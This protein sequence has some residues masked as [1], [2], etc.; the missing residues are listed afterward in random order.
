MLF[1][2]LATDL[3]I[4]PIEDMIERVHKI[5]AD[6]LG[7]AHQEEERL[8]FEELAMHEHAGTSNQKIQVD[9]GFKD[10]IKEREDK[11]KSNEPM[12][13][14]MLEQTL[15]KIGALLALGFG[16][17]GSQ[18]IAKNMAKGGD[19]N[20]MLPGIK[21][22]SIFGFCDIR[23]FTDA[24]E[25]LQEGVMLFVNEIGEICH[26]IVDR[27]SGAANKNI[28][29]AFLLVWKFDPQD[30]TI[31]EE[32]GDITAKESARVGQLCD[33]SVISFVL[34]IAELKKSR[35]MVKYNTHK[36]LIERMGEGYEVKLGMGLHMGYAIEGAIG[37]YYKIDASYLSPHVNMSARLEGA[38]KAFGVPLLISGSLYVKCTRR[39][40][41]HCR[42]VDWVVMA[43]SDEPVKL[44]TVDVDSSLLALESPQPT[45]TEKER[46]I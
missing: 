13:T 14:A 31:D 15:S 20:P 10:K 4:S 42:Q 6:P 17:A 32:T 26:G 19:V 1:S 37:S 24:T 43:G 34:L 35:K 11:D 16:E 36:G 46:K 45:L 39:M 29:D 41:G 38:T 2:K 9:D 40:K 30:Q 44:Y 27:Y 12:E 7:A 33:M 3:V 23:N 25:V 5:T 18:I 22:M 28:G 8:L 21:L